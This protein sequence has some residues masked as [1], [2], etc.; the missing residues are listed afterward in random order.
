M[1]DRKVILLS[2]VDYENTDMYN[3][4][5]GDSQ[6]KNFFE[7]HHFKYEDD[8]KHKWCKIISEQGI[9]VEF[10]YFT[11]KNDNYEFEH[12]Y[13][14]KVRRI[15]QDLSFWHLRYSFRLFR[16]L[17]QH[18]PS[19]IICVPYFFNHWMLIDMFDILTIFL[20]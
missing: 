8:P 4:I 20:S 2:T 1:E 11:S 7:N 3:M 18:S 9:N 6:E 14:H 16:K 13:G 10:W 17:K 5:V 12:K 19:H 15:K